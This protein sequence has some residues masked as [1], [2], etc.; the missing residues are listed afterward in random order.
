MARVTSKELQ[1]AGWLKSKRISKIIQGRGEIWF[2]P[3]LSLLTRY[4]F[5]EAVKAY[6]ETQNFEEI[7]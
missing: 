5:Q 4:T 3:K 6:K 7:T 2:H 1:L